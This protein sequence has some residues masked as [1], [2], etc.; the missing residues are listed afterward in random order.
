VTRYGLLLT[1]FCVSTVGDAM[2]RLAVPL[3]VF[4]VTGSSLSMA[5]AYAAAFVPYAVV[6]PLGGVLA[7]RFD[8][9][10]IL[11]AGDICAGVATAA[12]AVAA[13]RGGVSLVY[14]LI[15]VVA[16]VGSA[17]HPAFQSMIPALVGRSEL[18]KAN[19]YLVT[20]ENVIRIV[21]PIAGGAA[22]GVIGAV[23]AFWL[24]A[25]SFFG[26]ALLIAAIR[27]DADPG[28]PAAAGAREGV[29]AELKRGLGEAWRI[30]V[31]KWSVPLLVAGNLAAHMV[32]GNIAY[33]LVGELGMTAREFGIV[34]GVAGVGALIGGLAAP[35]LMRLLTPVRVLLACLV[36][37]GLSTALLLFTE[38]VP[39]IALARAVSVGCVGIMVV[40]Y[41][42]LRHEAVPAEILGRTVGVTR[43]MTALAIPL[44]AMTGGAILHQT[45]SFRPVVIASAA[46]WIVTAIAGWMV[47]VG[48]RRRK[49]P[50]V[51]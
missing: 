40:T 41:F 1:A 45:G 28:R 18:A 20:S 3:F 17:Y 46:L 13:M 36:V 5:A 35:R 7:D 10:R 38:R 32:N 43:A 44:A 33:F 39:G 19:A 14:L 16:C 22:I 42:T 49:R 25:A 51:A 15:L 9:R 47:P 21:A 37:G 11:I 26:S 23:G 4:D 2:F 8:R 24:N 31:L 34:F 27:P 6:M 29:V 48:G 12:L 30:P 50:A